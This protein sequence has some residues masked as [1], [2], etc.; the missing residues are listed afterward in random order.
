MDH[1]KNVVVQVHQDEFPAAS[2]ASDAHAG[3]GVD[4]LLRL[5]VP[6]DGRERQLRAHDGA[7]DQVRPQVRDD[8]L[9]FWK[10]RHPAD[11]YARTTASFFMSAQFAPTLVSTSTPVSSS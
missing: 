8:R 9:Y 3:D 6:D 10:F 2:H 5:R 4:E 7:P 1:E 11:A